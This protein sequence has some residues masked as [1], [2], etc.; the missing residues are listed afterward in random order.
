MPFLGLLWGLISA[1]WAAVLSAASAAV[2]FV[3]ASRAATVMVVGGA[4]LLTVLLIPIPQEFQQLPGLV[5]SIPESVRWG[6]GFVE[7]KFGI[8]VVFGCLV[9]RFITRIVLKVLTS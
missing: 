9:T 5:A 3:I 6:L 8:T 2:S 7:M 4:V 1:A